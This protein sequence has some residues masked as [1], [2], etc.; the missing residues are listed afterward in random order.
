MTSSIHTLI[1]NEQSIKI[2]DKFIEK[3]IMRL[4]P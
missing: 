4:T 2:K 1:I 3:N